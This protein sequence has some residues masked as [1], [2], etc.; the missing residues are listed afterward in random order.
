MFQD[1][2][3]STQYNSQSFYYNLK[4]IK[5]FLNHIFKMFRKYEI[6]LDF[7]FTHLY[8]I[9]ATNYRNHLVD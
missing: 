1:K 3:N 2:K 4:K 6:I 5:T 8:F 7:P 9:I